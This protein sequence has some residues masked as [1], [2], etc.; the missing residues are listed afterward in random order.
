M[1]VANESRIEQEEQRKL[2]AY[3]RRRRAALNSFDRQ[4]PYGSR[5]AAASDLRISNST[6]TAVLN[7]RSINER[8]LDR[9]EEWLDRWFQLHPEVTRIPNPVSEPG[10]EEAV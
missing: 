4:L 5:L 3:D 9:I 8:A 1:I 7:G 6:V 2:L 10:L